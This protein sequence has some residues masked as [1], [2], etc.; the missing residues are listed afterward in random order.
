MPKSRRIGAALLW[1]LILAGILADRVSWASVSQWREDQATNLWLGLTQPLTSIPV[2]LT[3]SV[4]LPNPNGM[5]V[6]GSLLSRLPSLWAVSTFL[7]CLQA[8]LVLLTCW[9]ASVGS[10]RVFILASAPLLTSVVLRGS[11]V[12]FWNQ[13]LM[14]TMNLVFMLWAVMY[15]RAPTL[16]KV[17]ALVGLV[18]FSP[19]LYLAGL[20]NAVVMAGIGAGLIVLSPPRAWRQGWS[21]TLLVFVCVAA[22]LVWLVWLPYF[23]AVP[24][25]QVI[26]AASHASAIARIQQAIEAVARFPVWSTALASDWASIAIFQNDRSVLSEAALRLMKTARFLQML[27][28]TMSLATLLFALSRW[29][30]GLTPRPKALADPKRITT[31]LVIIALAFVIASF[32]V[33]PL[34]GGPNWATGERRDQWIQFF[35]MLAVFWFLAPFALD[36]PGPAKTLARTA[37]VILVIL[38][39][40][41][42]AVAGI[43]VVRSHLSYRGDKLTEADVPLVQKMELVDYLARDWRS[44]STTSVVPV[45]YRLGGGRWDWITGFGHNLDAWYEAPYTIGRAFD[46]DLLRRYGFRN[47]QEGTQE[48]SFGKGRYLV[49]YAFEPEPT[50]LASPV[51]HILFGRLRLTIAGARQTPPASP[52]V[53]WRTSPI[54][55]SLRPVRTFASYAGSPW[56]SQSPRGDPVEGIRTTSVPAGDFVTDCAGACN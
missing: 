17:P 1:L 23:E 47:A 2:G 5:V 3:S 45:D 29:R 18:V 40:A 25:D 55:L 41:T 7:G 27:Q 39:S 52:S 30:E 9:I 51:T 12:E 6:L 20:A 35:P 38:Y 53:G 54:S 19:A 48:R 24:F 10:K 13:S 14:T 26:A 37:T 4:G 28:A 43:Y 44:F 21:W 34:L 49:T 8:A 42:S 16:G 50:P 11:S 31:W 46:Y 56:R 36:L 33:S 22:A 32:A 15:I